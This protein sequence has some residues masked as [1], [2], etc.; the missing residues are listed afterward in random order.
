MSS[1]PRS[2]SSLN[3]PPRLSGS[4]QQSLSYNFCFVLLLLFFF[5]F[6]PPPRLSGSVQQSLSFNN[7]FGFSSLFLLP[8][9]LSGSVQQS[10]SFCTIFSY[11]FNKV[12]LTT[13]C[14]FCKMQI[15]DFLPP[16]RQ[17]RQNLQQQH[18]HSEQTFW[19]T[20]T[21]RNTNIIGI[22]N[23]LG[24]TNTIRNVIIITYFCP[25]MMCWYLDTFCRTTI[26]E[27]YTAMWWTRRESSK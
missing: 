21:I 20:N 19:Y 8:S 11:Q 24:I 26:T 5:V 4:V 13:F 17:Q 6:L 14:V 1:P 27:M 3:L 2:P 15:W 7:F 23:T 9:R 12:F 18:R 25:M 16:G 10:L 22:T